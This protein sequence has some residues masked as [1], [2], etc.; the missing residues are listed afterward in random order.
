MTVGHRRSGVVD[1]ST[2]SAPSSSTDVE[3]DHR[4]VRRGHEHEHLHRQQRGE[5]RRHVVDGTLASMP[6]YQPSL[7]LAVAP[8][9]APEPGERARAMVVH[10]AP[11]A[12]S[13][14]CAPLRR[15]PQVEVDVLARPESRREAA[16]RRAPASTR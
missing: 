1:Q 2:P 14:R 3:G 8:H 11:T 13:R 5:Q 12:R 4:A 16:D 6:A 10:D 9:H 7:G 15:E